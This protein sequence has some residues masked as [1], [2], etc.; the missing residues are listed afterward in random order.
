ML[1]LVLC[2][3]A[4]PT[5]LISKKYATDISTYCAGINYTLSNCSG[6]NSNSTDSFDWVYQ[7]SY[8]NV[9]TYRMLLKEAG[10]SPYET[11]PDYN[12]INFLTI[13]ALFA[14][15]LFFVNLVKN[16]AAES[17]YEEITPSDYTLMVSNIPKNFKDVD[18]LKNEIL[19]IVL[20]ILFIIRRM[21][22]DP[23]I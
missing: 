4:I 16:L 6:L 7:M 19:E 10:L 22:L 8:Q 2:M 20:L 11:V 13:M 5:I 23:N 14:A 9:Y 21:I 12:L 17:D 15:N 18:E 3:A 1:S